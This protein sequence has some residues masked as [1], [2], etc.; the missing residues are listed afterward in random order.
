MKE[1]DQILVH[2]L[3]EKLQKEWTDEMMSSLAFEIESYLMDKEYGQD[4][5]DD[6]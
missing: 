1:T 3:L 5:L 2:L 6:L 4:G